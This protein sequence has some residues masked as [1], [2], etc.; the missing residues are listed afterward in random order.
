MPMGKLLILEKYIFLVYGSDILEKR[1]H[2][3]VTFAHRGYKRACKFWLE[4][5]IALDPAKPGD[6]SEKDLNE[7]KKLVVEHKA[8]LL[9]QL[10]LFYNHIPVKAIRK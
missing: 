7:I 5:D 4:P 8:T 2:V 3:H 10:D 1:R 9:K 6:F